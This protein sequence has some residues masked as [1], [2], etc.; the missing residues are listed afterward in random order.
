MRVSNELTPDHQAIVTVEVDQDQFQGAL[1]RAAQ[2]VSRLRPLH[3]FRPGKAPYGMVERAVGKDLLVEEA[4]EDLSKSLYPDILKENNI[5]PAD[6]GHL[7]VVQ[8]EPPI[9]KYTIPIKPRVHLGD[10]NSIHLTPAEVQVSDEEVNQVLE[11]FQMNQATMVPV[12]RGIQKGDTV[13]LGIKG[14]VPDHEPVDEKN[15]R[16]VI[17]DPRRPGVPF[18]DQLIGTAAGSTREIAYTYPEDY[19]DETFRGKTALY[20]ITV[21]DIKETQMPELNDEFAQ[22]V[23]QFQTLEQFRGNIRDILRRQKERDEESRFADQVVDALVDKSEISYP[24][25]MLERE[26]EHDLERTKEDVKKLGLTWDK[27]LELAGKNQDQVREEI[28]PRAEQELKRALALN[29]LMEIERPQVEREE[30]NTEIERRVQ[31][32][33]RAG[34]NANVARRSYT[35]R[36]ARQNIEFNLRLSKTVGK[37]VAMA[38]GEP[39]SGKI[40]TP[41]MLKGPEAS[42]IPTGLITDPS[43]VREADWPKGLERK[44]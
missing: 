30:V 9:F 1:R 18:E 24:P 39:I 29:Q 14:G 21:D 5:E 33:E 38:K 27:Y 26:I 8:K 25:V 17:G 32:T 43:Q 7:E 22:A 20:T 3:G 34:G 15:V 37:L 13:T 42:P 40:I 19:K 6:Q 44:S 12:S 41:D 11:R 16:V 10:Y 36:E 4:I 2:H 23:S 31:E 35:A 28:R